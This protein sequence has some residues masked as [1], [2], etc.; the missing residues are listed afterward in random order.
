MLNEPTPATSESHQVF[1]E[2]ALQEH[3]RSL[4]CYAMGFV[5]DWERARDVVQDTFVRLCQQ[6]PEK[7]NGGLKTW[8]FTVCRNRA[9]DVLRKES[10]TGEIDEKSLLQIPS[11]APTP[12]AHLMQGEKERWLREQLGQLSPRQREVIL[13]KFQQGMSYE[14]ISQVTGLSSGN[15]GFLIHQGIKRLREAIPALEPIEKA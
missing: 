9:L 12:D 8:L 15:I 3:E 1:I 14:E 13:L 5:H 6:E 4:I 2:R 10:R 11:A 7:V